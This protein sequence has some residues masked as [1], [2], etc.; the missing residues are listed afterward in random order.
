MSIRHSHNLYFLEEF[1]DSISEYNHLVFEFTNE[2][3]INDEKNNIGSYQLDIDQIESSTN[4]F[5]GMLRDFAYHTLSKYYR[6]QNKCI[7]FEFWSYRVNHS[8]VESP[9]YIHS[10]NDNGDNIH[11]FILYTQKDD[12][13]IDGN[14]SIYDSYNENSSLLEI[15]NSDCF[16]VKDTIHIRT[17]TILCLNGDTVHCP[18]KMSGYGIRNCIVLMFKASK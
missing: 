7:H 16:E 1:T 11:T 14:L 5:I 6:I 17:G 4:P 2:S 3:F 12:T 8:K 10:D 18:N 13:I 15:C 9:L